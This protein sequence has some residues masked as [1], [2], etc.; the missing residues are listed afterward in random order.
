MRI[1]DMLGWQ[2][3][4]MDM[5]NRFRAIDEWLTDCLGAHLLCHKIKMT[6]YPRRLLSIEAVDVDGRL[7]LV[8]T[9]RWRETHD[10]LP[11][12]VA[13]SH[14]WGSPEKQPPKTTLENLDDHR[15]GI[16][17]TDLPK[18]FQDAILI[19][20]R[21]R[22]SYLWID[23]LAIIQ[24]DIRDWQSEAANMAA[25]YENSFLTIAATD[26]ENCHGGCGIEPWIQTVF[27]G[28]AVID[29]LSHSVPKQVRL[30]RTGDRWRSS[31]S[32]PL[33]HTRGWTLQEAVL[34]RRILHMEQHQMLWQ[35]RELFNFEDPDE[36]LHSETREGIPWNLR[37][38]GF[39][40]QPHGAET[41]AYE[42][43][44]WSLVEG[45]SQR[46]F[47]HPNDKLPAFAGIIRF[48]E[49]QFSETIL[50]GLRK[51]SLAF[52]LGWSCKETPE[53]TNIADRMPGVPSWT[54]LSSHAAIK[55][56][57]TIPNRDVH[58]Q[59]ELVE[60]GFQWSGLPY[61]S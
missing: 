46:D 51:A 39:I 31:E 47:T 15:R 52:D 19:T 60:C 6:G 22:K 49:Q 10:V 36:Y 41:V 58:S 33:L 16:F 44:W 57:H 50:L 45:Y 30:K 59:L 13:L 54:W 61:V 38:A 43:Y 3:T 5:T 14:C 4:T 55:G 40:W 25:I 34:S 27:T 21:L 24:D 35:C 20:R 37:T 56:P 23:S 11:E 32:R 53:T 48:Y 2:T 28:K 8:E 29:E 42:K 18:T 1:N 26:A 12:Y 9:D 7:F 17:M